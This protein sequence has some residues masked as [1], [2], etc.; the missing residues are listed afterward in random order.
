MGRTVEQTMLAWAEKRR[1]ARE[2]R[3][4]ENLYGVMEALKEDIGRA[5]KSGRYV[6]IYTRDIQA[7]LDWHIGAPA[8]HRILLELGARYAQ[9]YDSE[10][11]STIRG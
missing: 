6:A 2:K 1:V 9:I 7:N 8:I 11:K 4:A 5:A 3:Q 10:L